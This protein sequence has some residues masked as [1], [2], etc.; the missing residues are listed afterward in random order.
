MNTLKVEEAKALIARLSDTEAYVMMKFIYMSWKRIASGLQKVEK[1][2]RSDIL[3]KAHTM[4]VQRLGQCCIG[5]F[6]TDPFTL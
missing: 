2:C 5:R 4:I 1:Y 6:S 3:L